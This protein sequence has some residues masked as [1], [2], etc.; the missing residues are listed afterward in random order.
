MFL[1]SL[2]AAVWKHC[3]NV[4][5]SYLKE[6]ASAAAASVVPVRL[7]E[8]HYWR[9]FGWAVCSSIAVLTRK[10][11]QQS[12]KLSDSD[13]QELEL[14]RSIR[15]QDKNEKCSVDAIP[16]LLQLLD[17]GWLSYLRPENLHFARNALTKIYARCEP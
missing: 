4:T 7:E 5:R 6:R 8:K 15:L 2:A 3:F 9:F 10:Q 17:E 12:G 16:V 14:L 1:H 11:K 13:C